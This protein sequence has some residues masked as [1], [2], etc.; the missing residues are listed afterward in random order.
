MCSAEVPARVSLDFR[1]DRDLHSGVLESTSI[2]E[3][4]A[5]AAKFLLLA[6]HGETGCRLSMTVTESGGGESLGLFLFVV[7]GKPVR[8][9]II[10]GWAINVQL[11]VAWLEIYS[12]LIA[13]KRCCFLPAPGTG[14]IPKP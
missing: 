5:I 1:F 9:G 6:R 10:P 3:V 8:D 4:V 11:Q 13:G 7:L 12:S 14:S 2:P